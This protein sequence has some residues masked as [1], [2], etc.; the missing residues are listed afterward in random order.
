MVSIRPQ[1]ARKVGALMHSVGQ[2]ADLEWHSGSRQHVI[3]S[4]LDA[5]TECSAEHMHERMR[6][7][8][9]GVVQSETS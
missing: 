6:V 4:R 1:F 3:I 7:R 5:S 2:G 8:E 9:T